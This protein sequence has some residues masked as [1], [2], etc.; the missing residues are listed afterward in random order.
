[1]AAEALGACLLV[2]LD[3]GGGA[4]RPIAMSDC[5]RRIASRAVCIQYGKRWQEH[6]AP[7]QYGVQTPGGA[8]Q[9]YLQVNALLEQHPDWVV[10]RWDGVNAF[11][12][13]N[14]GPLLDQLRQ[15]FPELLPLVGQ[16]YLGSGKLFFRGADGVTVT[17]ASVSGV[18]QGD[19]LGPFLY[20]LGI[21]PALV[22]LAERYR[23]RVWVLAYLDDIHLV[24]PGREVARAFCALRE[25]LRPLGQRAAPGKCVAWSPRGDYTAFLAA[26]PAGETD[27]RVSP[28]GFDVLGVPVGAPA[29]LPQR[30]LARCTDVG[31]RGR[32]NFAQKL[33]ALQGLAAADGR[34]GAAAALL[35]ARTCALPTCVYML[36]CLPPTV[37]AAAAAAI[38]A[39]V[40]SFVAELATQAGDTAASI[41]DGGVAADI[42]SLPIADRWGGLGLTSAALLAPLAHAA[43]FLANAPAVVARLGPAAQ[44]CAVGNELERLFSEVYTATAHAAQHA[45]GGGGGGGSSAGGSGAA[46]TSGGNAGNNSRGGAERA[47]LPF[48]RALVDLSARL[49]QELSLARDQNPFERML[50]DGPQRE[51]QRDF[52][53]RAQ[54]RT[55]KRVSEQAGAA[56]RATVV[57]LEA[58]RA[59][60][61]GAFLRMLPGGR[62]APVRLPDGRDFIGGLSGGEF[63]CALARRLMMPVL[64]GHGG[65]ACPLCGAAAGALDAWGDHVDGC[66]G[67]KAFDTYGH[68][69]GRDAL[70]V[71]AQQARL[72]PRLEVVHL[73]PTA[74]LKR[75]ADILLRS[76][77][78]HGLARPGQ[79]TDV[80]KGVCIDVTQRHI[81]A[82]T[83]LG[84]APKKVLEDAFKQ[85]TQRPTPPQLIP[86]SIVWSSCGSFHEPSLRT[87]LAKWSALRWAGADG[88]DEEQGIRCAERLVE[89]SWLPLLSAAAHRGWARKVLRLRAALEG[90]GSGGGATSL[91]LSD[92]LVLES[93]M[94][95][96]VGSV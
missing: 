43:A 8:E 79:P 65:R 50:A 28:D 55:R 3:K 19:P 9:V 83:Y 67:L 51:L 56:G 63:R 30:V 59:Y 45:A 10:L 22:T 74:P 26:L 54:Q 16:F 58:S 62:R 57:K 68:N 14:R 15:L 64:P 46:T 17:L 4:V 78:P 48:Q 73:D 95:V 72:R 96:L 60:G 37:T 69:H 23:G 47:A 53:E 49:T 2:A 5:L 38:D 93:D 31:A 7:Q 1:L 75:P 88:E 87:A 76:D 34:D 21:H 86:Y 77:V 12:T 39:L 40:R 24:G 32:P 35:L 29:D 42:L 71:V 81:L 41:D 20:A 18:Q 94:R 25:L 85:K 6:F 66:S 52:T 36:R 89:L 91:Q 84:S 11:N 80:G 61:A 90:D 33:A 82:P 27:V 44:R 70:C 92:V 13:I